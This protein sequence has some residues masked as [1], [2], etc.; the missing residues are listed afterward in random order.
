M[1]PIL[2][3]KNWGNSILKGKYLSFS[4]NNT[5]AFIDSFQ[6]FIFPSLDILA[7]N[8]VKDDFKYLNQRFNSNV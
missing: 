7:K 1:I 6:F 3:S 8:L 2:L 4:I 5:L